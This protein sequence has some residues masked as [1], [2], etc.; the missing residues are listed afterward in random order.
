MSQESNFKDN[1]RVAGTVALKGHPR[2]HQIIAKMQE[3]H[4]AKNTDYAAGMKEGPLGNFH[5]TAAIQ[6]LYPNMNWATPFGVCISYM[7]KQLDAALVLKSTQRQ[8][9]TGEPVTSRMNDVAVYS[10]LA[11]II[12]EEDSY[13]SEGP[14]VG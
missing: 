2:F 14:E 7:L 10:V 4:N 9:M 12:D 13:R 6:S 5:R 8:S 1:Q 3:L 11:M